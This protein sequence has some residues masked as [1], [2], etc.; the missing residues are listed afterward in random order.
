MLAVSVCY[1][2]IFRKGSG[3]IIVIPILVVD[4]EQIPQF[5]TGSL[6]ISHAFCTAG[7]LHAAEKHPGED[8]R[9][10]DIPIRLNEGMPSP[11]P[12]LSSGGAVPHG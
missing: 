2:V 1:G 7:R 12:V 6:K 11:H 8:C 10:R 5:G 4:A 9:S 3:V